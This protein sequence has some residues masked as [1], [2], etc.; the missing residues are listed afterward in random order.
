MTQTQPGKFDPRSIDPRSFKTIAQFQQGLKNLMSGT[1]HTGG[2]I[3]RKSGPGGIVK[4]TVHENTLTFRLATE[5]AVSRIVKIC[6]P[7]DPELQSWWLDARKG[8]DVQARHEP[9][10]PQLPPDQPGQP[11]Q[12]QVQPDCVGGG[13]PGQPGDADDHDADDRQSPRSANWL[14]SHPRLVAIL[15]LTLMVALVAIV[16]I[17]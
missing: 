10:Q 5:Y 15:A 4:S 8:L 3:E 17:F 2:S 13:P 9:G 11:E 7:G 16:I 6:A 1:G 12:L 14:R